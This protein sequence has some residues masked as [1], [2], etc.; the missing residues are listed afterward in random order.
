M[1]R[2]LATT[3]VTHTTSTESNSSFGPETASIEN[4]TSYSHLSDNIH[5]AGS[6]IISLEKLH[7]A[8]FTISKHSISCLSPVELIGEVQR[9]GLCSTLLA[10]FSKEIMF[11]TCKIV[12]L[13]EPNG[14][15]RSTYQ[16][17]VTAVMGQ[18]STGGGCNNLEELLCAI[19]IPSM[20]KP[21]FIKIE[22][23]LGSA[24]EIYL[25]ELMLQ[26]G[27]E[28]KNLATQNSKYHQNI[29]AITVIV[30]GG[31]SKRS[32]KHSHN[33]NS[34]VEVIFGAVTFIH[35]CQK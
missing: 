13:K 3:H 34:E 29:P 9:N 10:K 24:F 28:E 19:G 18:M 7:D 20:T 16:S 15:V 1:L 2:F 14:T 35:G 4:I 21:T 31:W 30:D 25:G 23:P 5:L 6:R 26:A 17:N 12:K 8:I 11:K 22:R 32:H 33:A 27:Q